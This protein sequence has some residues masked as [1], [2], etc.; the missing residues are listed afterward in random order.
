MS[1]QS[2]KFQ[3]AEV[4]DSA[5][6][7]WRALPSRSLSVSEAIPFRVKYGKKAWLQCMHRG[8]I[9]FDIQNFVYRK[10]PECSESKIF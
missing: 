5:R 7:L 1:S 4:E 8:W 9:V 3:I 10:V 2:I 6:E